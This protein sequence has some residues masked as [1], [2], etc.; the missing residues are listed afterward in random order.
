MTTGLAAAVA[1]GGPSISSMLVAAVA[2]G[3]NK[4]ARERGSA[5]AARAAGSIAD[6]V[7]SAPDKFSKWL[8]TLQQAAK[9]GAEG[10]SVSHHLLMNNDPEYRRMVEE[11]K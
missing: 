9:R 5:F 4:I 8:P 11:R 7:D 2:G 1:G 3:A 6:M 10:L